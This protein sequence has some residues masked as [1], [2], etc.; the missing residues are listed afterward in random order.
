MNQHNRD[1]E[2]IRIIISSELRLNIV[3]VLNEKGPLNIGSL[4]SNLNK[5]R[6]LIK[7]HISIL[8]KSN[9]IMQRNY[10]SLK[11]YELTEFGKRLLAKIQDEKMKKENE[12]K[13][14]FGRFYRI[15]IIIALS[16]IPMVLATVKFG[17]EKTHPFWI[18]G[19]FII[20]L[21]VY[22]IL[23]KIWK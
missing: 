16:L 3:K 7:H 22:H 12:K 8:E 6:Q 13:L 17:L 15:S 19:G 11:V 10:G 5:S 1:I 21:L 23:N 20:S 18:I 9:I 14:S 4:S 2:G